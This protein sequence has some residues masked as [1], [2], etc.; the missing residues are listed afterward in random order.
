M[1]ETPRGVLA[2]DEIAAAT[3]AAKEAIEVQVAADVGVPSL[4][5]PPPCLLMG[6]A[7]LAKE[8]RVAHSTDRA[9]M[10]TA[11]QQCVL[12]GRAHQLDVLDG[13]HLDLDDDDGFKRACRQVRVAVRREEDVVNTCG[14][15]AT[16]AWRTYVLVDGLL[17]T[18]WEY[19][20]LCRLSFS[21]SLPP[22]FPLPPSSL[23]PSPLS[24]SSLP[25]SRGALLGST[26]RR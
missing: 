18:E 5:L 23:S 26:E 7:D 9:A 11:L 12:A 22:S 4:S 8:L 24:L 2:A 14:R 10:V 17:L 6:T 21:P 1:I 13:V 20:V 15:V 19:V 3:A 16:L 25:L